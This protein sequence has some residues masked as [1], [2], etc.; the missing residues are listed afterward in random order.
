MINSAAMKVSTDSLAAPGETTTPN[1]TASVDVV[2]IGGGPAGSATSILLA[3]RGYRVV[4][5]EKGRHP[6]FHIRES[7]LPANLPIFER[8]G[9]ADQVR[10]IGMQKWGAEFVSP[11]HGGRGETFNFTEGWDKALPLSLPARPS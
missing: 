4:Q 5:L 10:A 9:V 2:I 6:R 11:W 7:L 3:E 8:L 1:A